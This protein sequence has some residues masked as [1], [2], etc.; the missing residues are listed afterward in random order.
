VCILPLS[1]QID[2]N[3]AALEEA[4]KQK[5]VFRKWQKQK[6]ARQVNSIYTHFYPW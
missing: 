6:G 1:Q 3:L 4:E 5:A 2:Q